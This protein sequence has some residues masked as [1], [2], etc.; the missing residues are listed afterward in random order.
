[1]LPSL[2]STDAFGETHKRHSL[3]AEPIPPFR[4]DRAESDDERK[5]WE[6]ITRQAVAV[7][8]GRSKRRIL[9]SE[10]F[11]EIESELAERESDDGVVRLAEIIREREEANGQRGDD[12]DGATRSG[13]AGSS[14]ADTA[15]VAVPRD[16]E[17]VTEPAP[18]VREAL[19]ILG[20][21]IT[22]GP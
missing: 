17:G 7:L 6:P 18:P 21:M 13:A 12:A 10:Y 15:G 4:S 8:A 11:Q 22:L 2:L 9:E 1:M 20:D 14:D 5:R 3:T 19:A 16:P